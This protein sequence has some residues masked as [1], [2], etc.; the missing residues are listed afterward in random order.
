MFLSHHNSFHCACHLLVL[1]AIVLF[2]L[3][4]YSC[5]VSDEID[6]HLPGTEDDASLNATSNIGIA[7]N[8]FEANILL[9]NTML[10]T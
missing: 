5:S 8:D 9:L 4:M 10:M 2:G 6:S 7:L 3:T 1:G